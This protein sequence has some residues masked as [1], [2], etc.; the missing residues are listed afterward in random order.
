MARFTGLDLS[1]KP[2]QNNAPNNGGAP[3]QTLNLHKF[4]FFEV[5]PLHRFSANVHT[6]PF[7]EV[8]PLKVKLQA[9]IEGGSFYAL[10][11][12]EAAV[13]FCD[14]VFNRIRVRATRAL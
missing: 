11:S 6:I 1:H 12:V 2:S 5:P 3:P 4:P 9:Q 10:T 14:S 13:N 8:S 7:L